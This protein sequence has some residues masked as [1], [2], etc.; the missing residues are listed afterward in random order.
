MKNAMK[1]VKKLLNYNKKYKIIIIAFY[2]RK[3]ED[4]LKRFYGGLFIEK[5]KLEEAG[6]NHPI[7]LEYYKR[8]NEDEVNKQKGYKFGISIVKT[9][10]LNNNLKV[11][12]KDIKHVT[13]DEIEADKILKIFK[14]NQVTPINSEEIISDLFNN[15]LKKIDNI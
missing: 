3:E 5:E 15:R 6:I 1:S 12:S 14:E 10:Y 13:N 7:K 8:I 11:E 4:I 2:E 9:E